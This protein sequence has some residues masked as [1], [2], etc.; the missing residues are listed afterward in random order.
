MNEWG[1]SITP[2]RQRGLHRSPLRRTL[3][4]V[5][6]LTVA[7]ALPAADWAQFRGS[8]NSGVSP[9]VGIPVKWSAQEGLRWKTPLPGRGLSNPVIAAGRVFV[10][11][12]SRVHQDRLHVLCF[13][14][15][16]G[17]RL[18][19]RQFWATGTTQSHPKT[20]MAA[21]TPVTD[22][23]FVYALFATADLFCL[24]RDGNL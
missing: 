23:R 9:E 5:A 6:L 20:N 15:S 3:A 17:K 18:W 11:A 7:I 8:D 4:I 12:S 13:D 10:T 14:A 24:D 19:E 22:G 2:K 1:L 16:D 21:P